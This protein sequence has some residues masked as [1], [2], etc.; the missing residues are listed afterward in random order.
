MSDL[1]DQDLVILAQYSFGQL[2]APQ[3][4]LMTDAF[5]H[6]C[7]F[8]HWILTTHLG[9]LQSPCGMSF[10]GGLR[11]CRWYIIELTTHL[12]QLQSPCGISFSGGLRH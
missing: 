10:S 1:K 12:G 4:S 9:Q 3:D 7:P 8:S 11:H 6:F 2:S 5:H